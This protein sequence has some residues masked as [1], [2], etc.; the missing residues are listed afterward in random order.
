MAEDR[1]RAAHVGATGNVVGFMVVA[2]VESVMMAP[3]LDV[4]AARHIG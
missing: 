2:V 1:A 4:V 3:I